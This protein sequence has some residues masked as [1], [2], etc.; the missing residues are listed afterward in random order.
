MGIRCNQWY[1]LPGDAEAF[2]D[3]NAVKEGWDLCPHCG[4]NT[5]T[6]TKKEQHDTYYGY[7][8]EEF[9]LNKYPLIDGGYAL[10]VLQAD[11]CDSGPMIYT[12]LEIYSPEGELVK[13][14][15]WDWHEIGCMT[16][17]EMEGLS[18]VEKFLPNS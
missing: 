4:E 1:G 17:E 9:P 8:D 11:P 3:K 12:K 2:L 15:L 6:R 16:P 7:W 14:F 18:I 5:K 13:S 10:E